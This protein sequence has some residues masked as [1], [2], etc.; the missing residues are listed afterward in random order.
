MMTLSEQEGAY[1]EGWLDVCQTTGHVSQLD[2]V[3]ESKQRLVSGEVGWVAAEKDVGS[4]EN[5]YPR[6]MLVKDISE[7]V[8]LAGLRHYEK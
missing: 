7:M 5:R 2:A 3:V 6:E 8:G 1:G 4:A